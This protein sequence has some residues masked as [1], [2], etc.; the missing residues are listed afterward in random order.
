MIHFR[1]AA[2]VLG[3]AIGNAKPMIEELVIKALYRDIGES[4]D[5]RRKYRTA[6]FLEVLGEV[7][8][9][10]Q[11]ANTYRGLSDDHLK[12]FPSLEISVLP[13]LDDPVCLHQFDDPIVERIR[14]LPAG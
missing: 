10:A 1:R 3:L 14:R 4:V 5:R 11:K 7:R 2:R 6:G 13:L 12:K 8:S 9:T